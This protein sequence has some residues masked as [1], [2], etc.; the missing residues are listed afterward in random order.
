M[1]PK[2]INKCYPCGKVETTTEFLINFTSLNNEEHKVCFK[3]MII[4]VG[5]TFEEDL[6]SITMMPNDLKK[7]YDELM[8]NMTDGL[9]NKNELKL[10]NKLVEYKT[11][12]S[13]TKSTPQLIAK[14]NQEIIRIQKKSD[15]YINPA[16]FIPREKHHTY[17][18][19][20]HIPFEN[21]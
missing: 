5:M 4:I 19:L 11:S 17:F 6:C 13:K 14:Y 16:T 12:D 21:N 18:A 1:N 7:L 2:T 8:S 3:C 9:P 15:C 10:F 20:M